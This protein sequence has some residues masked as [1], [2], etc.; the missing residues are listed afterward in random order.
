[1][2]AETGMIGPGS[3]AERLPLSA[4]MAQRACETRP[5][6]MR[7]SSAISLGKIS[8]GA[9]FRNA[10]HRDRSGSASRS[11]PAQGRLPA[12]ARCGPTRRRDGARA[13]LGRAVRTQ[14][15]RTR[16]GRWSVIS[17]LDQVRLRHPA[18]RTS[19]LARPIFSEP[20][21][22]RR[23]H[24]GRQRSRLPA[25][26]DLDAE[27]DRSRAGSEPISTKNGRS[28]CAEILGAGGA[29]ESAV[30]GTAGAGQSVT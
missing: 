19:H 4:A 16:A 11:V 26:T 14:T 10:G 25:W 1:M 15:A 7:R 6:A 23:T 22:R 21:S 30:S 5:N 28:P 27:L 3:A 2:R 17:C 13:L 24:L 8:L 18:P 9:R 29:L 12:P 20:C